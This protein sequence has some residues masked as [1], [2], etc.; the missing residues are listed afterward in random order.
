MISKRGGIPKTRLHF[1]QLSPG[2]IFTTFLY[3][4]DGMTI[5]A[6]DW[7]KQMGGR[8]IDLLGQFPMTADAM[9]LPPEKGPRVTE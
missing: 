2:R 3:P 7:S 9:L 4:E 6:K 8:M 1:Q 5:R